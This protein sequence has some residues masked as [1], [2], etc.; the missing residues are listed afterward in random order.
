MNRKSPQDVTRVTSI[1]A[2]PIGGGWS[3]HFL[4]HGYE[5]I[6]YLHDAGEETQLRR[7]IDTAWRSLEALGLSTDATR[8][9]LRCT[10]DLD[11]ALADAEFV[12]ESVPEDL[13][14]K[15][16]VYEQ[17]DLRT[18][19]DVV[20]ASSTSGLRMTDIQLRC[21]TPERTVAAHPFNPLYLLP[22]VEIVGG[23]RTDPQT[24]QWAAEFY[25]L[26]GKSPLRLNKE[27][28][29]YVASRLQEALWR[30]ALHM[31]ANGEASVEQIDLAM[32]N[33]PGERWAFMGPC[34]TFHV[35]GGEGGMAYGVWRIA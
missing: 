30:E 9:R 31:V 26:S 33:G 17:L 25:R 16:S 13:S 12:Q 29:G 18:P 19:T 34:M 7:L 35:G 15:Q 6:T 3:A 11:E 27:V 8:D 20:I 2:G 28:P 14:L 22:L 23:E 21:Q 5:V 10:I 1:G 32:V 4:A 24:V